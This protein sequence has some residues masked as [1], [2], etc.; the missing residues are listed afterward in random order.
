MAQDIVDGKISKIVIGTIDRSGDGGV[1]AGYTWHLD[2]TT[3]DL[4]DM[5]IELCD[6]RPS[7]VAR[8][9]WTSPTY[10]PWGGRITELEKVRS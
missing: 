4:V 5:T 3:V 10:C 2:P 8:A 7:A 1:N 6:G 9:G